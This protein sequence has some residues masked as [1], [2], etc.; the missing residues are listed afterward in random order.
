MYMEEMTKGYES[1]KEN[2]LQSI[3][4]TLKRIECKLKIM[5]GTKEKTIPNYLPDS[6]Q[7]TEQQN[8]SHAE[9]S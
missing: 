3:D 2:T 8:S 4:R 7:E 6:N 1:A 9:C 5:N